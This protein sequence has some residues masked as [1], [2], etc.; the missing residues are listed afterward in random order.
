[1]LAS[2]CVKLWRGDEV[3]PSVCHRPSARIVC[4]KHLGP[5]MSRLAALRR[6]HH[7]RPD[8]CRAEEIKEDIMYRRRPEAGERQCGSSA[9]ARSPLHLVAVMAGALQLNIEKARIFS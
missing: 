4:R 1:M 2:A 8:R 5:H 3:G 6:A 9:S 7:G